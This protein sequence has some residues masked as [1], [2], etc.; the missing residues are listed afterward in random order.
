MFGK[1]GAEG[2]QLLTLA[3]VGVYFAG[4]R[5]HQRT[6][7]ERGKGMIYHNDKQSTQDVKKFLKNNPMQP[8]KPE[9]GDRQGTP[10]AP[11]R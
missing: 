9:K 5:L 11:T 1:P 7:I 6:N 2:F 8:A 4:K 3:V 10:T